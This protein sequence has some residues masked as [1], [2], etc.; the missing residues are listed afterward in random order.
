MNMRLLI[1]AV[2]ALA[3][4]LVSAME[5][6]NVIILYA[7]DMGVGDVSYGD[8]EAK[9]QTPNIDRLASQGMTFTDGHSSSGICTPSRYA[10]LTGQH[11]WRRF[12]DIV[13]AFGES[14][15]EPDEFTIARM[16]KQ[17]G[18]RT[19]MFGKWHLGWGWDA[20][21]KPG[22]DKKELAKASSYD[23]TKR[24]PGGPVDQ[25]F[26]HYFGDGTINFPPYC[27]IENDRF[28]TIPTKPVMK[29]KPL[30]GGGGFRAGPMAED[31]N[32]YDIL[33]TV[34]EK[35]V[36]WVEEQDGDAPFFV[37]LAF[38]SPHYPIVPN[39]AFHGKSKAGYYG[40]F[41]IE[42]D[43]MVGKV[44]TA[45]E[46]K[47]L[48][49][50]TVVVFSADNGTENHCLTRLQK[51]DQWS[52]GDFRGMKR[53]LYEGGH[54]IPFI[55][56][57][58]GKIKAGSRSAEVVSQ[59]DLAATFADI[60]GHQLGSDEAIDS[61]SILPVL[62]GEDYPKP[63][64]TATVQN[65]DKGKYALRQG[66]WVFINAHSGS[67]PRQE[68]KEY[69]DYFGLE[70]YSENNPCLLFNLKDDPRQSNNLYNQYPEKV[71]A[72]RA[73]LNRYVAGEPCVEGKVN[74][75]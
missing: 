34:T 74:H 26:D 33:P 71:S 28:L 20:I 62:K 61:Y 72:M 40:D 47:G 43:A 22:V 29:S 32:P 30:A 42:T 54:R 38:N 51:F 9:I 25:G 52:S 60:L 35:T 44:M 70:M 69:L 53:D 46:K 65:T 75:E 2:A 12:H 5:K 31:W 36:E 56:S 58:P 49:E 21:R 24:F 6:P 17:Q 14:V 27:W 67:S 19:A 41:V 73:L 1:F 4:S 13:G 7:D 15:F 45:L 8:P 3:G 68:P 39:K 23:W 50:N 16:F 11:H 63:L 37:Y 59:V 48:L 55:V 57:W 18:Y 10:M 66:D 64:R